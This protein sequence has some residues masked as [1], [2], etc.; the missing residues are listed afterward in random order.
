MKIIER[1]QKD[2][3][4]INWT[5]DEIKKNLDLVFE[6]TKEDLEKIKLIPKKDRNF[7]NT[8][9]AYETAGNLDGIEAVF[10][11]VLFCV[12]PN[13]D[14]RDAGEKYFTEFN[15]KLVDLI[16][17][18]DLYRAFLEYNP[19]KEKLTG[20]E[21][22]LYKD[23][24]D[25]YEKAGFHLSPD[26]QEE[27]KKILKDINNISNKFTSNISNFRKSILC[28]EKELEG[29]SPEYINSLPKDEKTGKYIVDTSYP[30]Y[31]PFIRFAKSDKK[32]KELADLNSQ[33]GAKENI[34]I[35]EK[36]LELRHKKAKILGYKNYS[37][38]V[39]SSRMAKKTENVKNILEETI[40]L[41]KNDFIK[42]EKKIDLYKSSITGNKNDKTTYYDASYYS[43]LYKKEEYDLDEQKIK[44]YFELNNVLE[45]MFSIFGDLFNVS[46][47]KNTDLKLWHEDLM[48]FDVI[49]KSKKIAIL[50][51]DM[52]P[53]DG[54][55]SHMAS[56]GIM[57]GGFKDYP[58]NKNYNM[59]VSMIMG[60][61]P[62]GQNGNPSLLSREE[63]KTLFHEFGHSCHTIFSRAPFESQFGTDTDFDFLETPSQLF[64]NWF[65]DLKLMKKIS[66][67]Y[68]TGDSLDDATITSIKKL[69]EDFAVGSVYYTMA[70]GL[71]DFNFHSGKKITNLI[72]YSEKFLGKLG[73]RDSSPKNLFPAGWGHM[74]GYASSYYAYSVSLIYAY[75]IF[76]K[77]EEGGIMN[78]KL[79]M[80][81]RNKILSKGG[82][83]DE[84]SY[85]KDF[86][87]RKPNNKAF[88]KALGIKK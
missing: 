45:K 2:F 36:L 69:R 3:E 42:S 8:I 86:L 4:W 73:M 58:K 29:L 24:K 44:E 87:G 59:P 46:F 62:K 53:R 64:E 47:S 78:K 39:L 40:K 34:K 68:K 10:A 83:E 48:I 18:K 88:L 9:Y 81:L 15:S 19:K 52:F 38:L 25:F 72:N 43:Q 50:I 41:M 54:K 26:K 7:L 56:W 84:F 80:E 65:N 61:F 20:P 79:G 63:V 32:R 60:N 6:K 49:E 22:E 1:T 55:Y 67:H 51:L 12:S 31:G 11:E 57:T 85:M 74:N 71:L 13:K 30:V 16:Y 35:L 37:D 70:L 21:K 28:N 23:Q 33:K 14:Q 77:F 5:P 27:L 76:S 75:D 17:D 66:K 82:S